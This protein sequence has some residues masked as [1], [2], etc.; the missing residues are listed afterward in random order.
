MQVAMSSEVNTLGHYL[1]E[2]SEKNRHT[3]D[4]TLN[5]LTNAIMEVIAAFPVYRTY[6]NTWASMTGTGRSSNWLCPRQ[7][8]KTRDQRVDLRLPEGCAPAPLPEGFS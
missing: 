2:L 1:D 6:T 3:Q 4:F 8:G 5:S 7:R